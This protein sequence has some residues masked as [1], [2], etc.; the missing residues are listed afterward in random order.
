MIN[1]TA[2]AF[3]GYPVTDMDRARGFYE[4]VLGLKEARRWE[5]KGRA[6]IEYELGGAALAVTNMAMEMWKPSP[7]GPSAALEVADFDAAIDALRKA[8]VPFTVEPVDN[9]GCRLAV[10]TDPDGNAIAIHCLN[11]T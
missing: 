7:D 1:A 3:T 6:W 5:H 10:V 2:I 9:G 4:G 8:G 11:K